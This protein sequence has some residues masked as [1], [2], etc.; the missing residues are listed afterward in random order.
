M[1]TLS[2]KEQI[3]ERRKNRPKM[4]F[5]HNGLQSLTE[6][7]HKDSCDINTIVKTFTPDSLQQHAEA[8]KG[9]Y[10]DFT[11]SDFNESMNIVANVKSM[12]EGL[13]SE[14][15]KT[16]GND[17]TQFLDFVQNP[18]NHKKV[19]QMGIKSG[20]DG[21]DSKGESLK[22]KVEDDAEVSSAS[23]ETSSDEGAST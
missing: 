3:A 11:S 1:T 9:R 2:I 5:N 19:Q 16:F 7:S 21:K 20:L 10:D 13:P 4:D 22:P 23:P 15:R 6:Q 14:T 18:E 17:P 8:Y 12:F